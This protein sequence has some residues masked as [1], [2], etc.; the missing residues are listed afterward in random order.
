MHAAPSQRLKLCLLSKTLFPHGRR[1]LLQ[2][3]DLIGDKRRRTNLR[4]AAD[5]HWFKSTIHRVSA[6]WSISFIQQLVPTLLGT[7]PRLQCLHMHILL[8]TSLAACAYASLSHLSRRPQGHHT[9]LIDTE[10]TAF[11]GITLEVAYSRTHRLSDII[12]FTTSNEADEFPECT[13]WTQG[14]D[15]D[16]PQYTL[17]RTEARQTHFIAGH[18]TG[19]SSLFRTFARA[20]HPAVTD[21]VL[22][23][24]PSAPFSFAPLAFFEEAESVDLDLRP[25]IDSSESV[26]TVLQSLDLPH[27][28]VV[29]YL[30]P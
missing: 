12:L 8:G 22:F 18:S 16:G 13:I 10:Q 1:V 11:S 3:V 14:S 20:A 2:E 30:H 15:I 27:S 7:G 21:L 5:E 17:G 25:V 29:L 24:A 26:I 4:I 9:L 6:R 23:F 19:T 28:V